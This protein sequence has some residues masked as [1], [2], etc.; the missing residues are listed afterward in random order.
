M[1]T[2]TQSN[3]SLKPVVGPAIAPK[4][5]RVMLPVWA[6][7]VGFAAIIGFNAPETPQFEP[8]VGKRSGMTLN[9]RDN[10]QAKVAPLNVAFVPASDALRNRVLASLSRLQ[11]DWEESGFRVSVAP[12]PAAAEDASAVEFAQQLQQ[13][14]TQNKLVASAGYDASALD[15]AEAGVV[16]QCRESDGN[17]ARELA[18]AMAP[19]V[20]G[21][22]HIVYSARA[23]QGQFDVSI[24]GSPLFNATGVAYFPE[25]A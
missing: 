17:K 9:L 7:A 3:A 20:R 14:F 12:T 25:A 23:T 21:E 22:V 8:L 10:T 6:F 4:T 19:L 5:R 24:Q 18:L 13:W 11:S 1:S 16:I 2:D 15:S